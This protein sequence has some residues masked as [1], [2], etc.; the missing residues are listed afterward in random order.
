MKILFNLL[1]SRIKLLTTV[2]LSV[3]IV[4][5]GCT[6][7]TN[8]VEYSFK[9]SE[10][11]S[12]VN[13]PLDS[14]VFMRYPYRLVKSDSLLFILDLHGPE[15]FIHSFSIPT[16]T[17]YDSLC[18]VG[19]GPGEFVS[20]H[21]IQLEGDT[22]YVYDSRNAIYM[23]NTKDLYHGIEK[24]KKIELTDE[25]GFLSR[26]IKLGEN[27]YFP[28]FNEASDSR[29]LE[30]NNRGEII[31]SFG[32]LPLSDSHT[33]IESS[34]Y[35]AWAPIV[36]G[37]DSTLV[38]VTQFGDVID[39]YHVKNQITEG[40]FGGPIFR[41]HN[42]YAIHEGIEG[43]QDVVVKD[44]TIFALFSGID[45]KNTDANRQGGDKIYVFDVDGNPQTKLFLDRTFISTYKDEDGSFLALDVNSDTPLYRFHVP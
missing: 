12:T 31:D 6:N 8:Y 23:Y 35:Q 30:L 9:S 14:S 4:I 7:S 16:L 36:G 37:E 15:N 38:T 39:I 21:D 17:Y 29:M 33:P 1:S 5:T 42:G 19:D 3:I 45:M 25:L 34:T 43:F 26:G 11:V 24:P 22:L 40:E 10:N 18:K 44:N 27:F 41:N 32:E 13:I 28:I 2:S 20:I